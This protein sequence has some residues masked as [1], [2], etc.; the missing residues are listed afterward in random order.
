MVL[1]HTQA[2]VGAGVPEGWQAER[3]GFVGQTLGIAIPNHY[4]VLN[5]PV[6]RVGDQLQLHIWCWG[7]G[8]ARRSRCP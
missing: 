4:V 8:T 2:M 1:L 7:R 6:E 3:P 5:C